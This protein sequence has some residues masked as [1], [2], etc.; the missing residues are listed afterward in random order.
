[1]G[2]F[3]SIK[4]NLSNAISV[5]ERDPGTEDYPIWCHP[6][7]D[8][9]NGSRLIVGPEDVALLYDNGNISEPFSGGNYELSTSNYPFID[10]LRAAFSGGEKCYKYRV[11]FINTKEMTNLKWGTATPI[12]APFTV[13]NPKFDALMRAN[14][15]VPNNVPPIIDVTLNL[16][17][18]GNYSLRIENPKLFLQKYGGTSAKQRTK[19]DLDRDVFGPDLMTGITDT[20]A[21]AVASIDNG[22]EIQ[23]KKGEISK[24]LLESLSGIFTEYGT[25][26][27]N[28]KIEYLNVD[29]NDP[30]WKKLRESY[31][32]VANDQMSGKDMA[33]AAE[34]GIQGSDW[35]RIQSRNIMQGMVN[36]PGSGGIAAAGAGLGMGIAAGNAMGNLASGMMTPPPQATPQQQTVSVKCPKCGADVNGGKFC[37]N[38]GSELPQKKFCTNCGTEIT[39]GAKF[40]SNCGNK[41]E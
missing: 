15:A 20:I 3:S 34:I 29:P 7:Q 37:S 22:L 39:P 5:I 27:T 14:G 9:R 16:Q 38:C 1:M 6:S 35:Q 30:E 19:W 31:N 23:G 2:L 36:N 41:T 12:P 17:L 8:F 28:F 18:R 21:N 33:E 24:K 11:F 13:K 10:S 25:R 26:L 32:R 4:E 40:C